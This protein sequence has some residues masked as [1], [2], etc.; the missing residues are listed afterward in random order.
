MVAVFSGEAGVDQLA[1]AGRLMS[2]SSLKGVPEETPGERKFY[3]ASFIFAT[4]TRLLAFGG[5]GGG[6]EMEMEQFCA[7]GSGGEFARGARN[8]RIELVLTQK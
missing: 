7:Q 6:I 5:T 4:P 2:G 1:T 8:R 3:K